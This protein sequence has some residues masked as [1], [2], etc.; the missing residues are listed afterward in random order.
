MENSRNHKKVILPAITLPKCQCAAE[1]CHPPQTDTA[2]MVRETL[3]A[4][5]T[6]GG[7]EIAGQENEGQRNFRGW[8]MQDWKR[9]DKSA[10]LENAG[11]E[12]DGQKC[13]RPNNV[14]L[15]LTYS[16]CND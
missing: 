5:D 3:I 11:L 7:A 13:S 12:I 10:E 15:T 2:Y 8:K 4:S 16:N 6:I 9:T 14:G 1:E